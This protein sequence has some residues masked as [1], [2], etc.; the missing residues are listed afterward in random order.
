VNQYSRRAVAALILSPDP[1]G[2]ALLAAAVELAGFRAEF[3]VDGEAAGDAVRRVK[4]RLVMLDARDPSVGDERL[5]GPALMIGAWVYLFGTGEALRNLEVA[6]A[7]HGADLLRLP[8]DIDRLPEL[9]RR[10]RDHRREQ[11]PTG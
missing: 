9:L 6:A 7:R 1:L 4:P 11:F 5:L 10:A 8:E 2:A 3:A